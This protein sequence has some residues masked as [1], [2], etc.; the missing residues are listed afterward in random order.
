MKIFYAVQATGNGH[1]SRAI[2][3]IPYLE[4]YG[5]VDVFLSGNNSQLNPSMNVKY[6]SK[7]LSLAYNK[8]GGL[9]YCKILSNLN[10]IRF[11]KEASD[12]PVD[13]YDV[14]LNDFESITSLAC[15]LKNKPSL[16]FGHQ[17]SFQS[18]LTPRPKIK[19]KLGE[20]V[21]KN[22]SR[23]TEYFGLH[24][25][26]YDK[27]IYSPILRRLIIESTPEKRDYIAVYLPQF[28][29]NEI[30]NKLHTIPQFQFIVHT[31]E[32]TTPTEN[33]NV[34]LLPV[35]YESFAESLINCKALITGAGFETP[36]EALYL[37]KKLMVIPIKGQ[38]E[39]LC[40]AEA[41]KEWNVSVLD[42]LEQINFNKINTLLQEDKLISY[43]LLY[44]TSEIVDG[45]IKK[46]LALNK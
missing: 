5:E 2:E 37:G 23:S 13:K 9:D 28:G 22:Y 1:L 33:R 29:A 44:S 26:P 7:G 17:A 20:F 12:L 18:N 16:Q 32:V 46:A 34:K 45:V 39:Q 4:K 8:N 21:L 38:Y 11:Y 3:L 36:A 10:P 6:R 24:F 14:V 42:D 41:L 15:R 25:W 35:N 40:N 27:N 43:N 31:K 30:L 19:D